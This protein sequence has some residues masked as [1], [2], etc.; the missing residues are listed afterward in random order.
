MDSYIYSMKKLLIG[1]LL[2]VLIQANAQQKFENE[3]RFTNDND[4]YTSLVNDR[5]YTNGIFLTYRYISKKSS[6]TLKKIYSWEI[7]QKMYTPYKSTELHL[8]EHDRPFAAYLYGAFGVLNTFPNGHILKSQLQ[9][10]VVGPS[11]LG[12]EMQTFVHNLYGFK[13]PEGWKYQIQNTLGLNIDLEYTIPI[14]MSEFKKVDLNFVNNLKAGT[15]FN[16]LSTGLLG[17]IGF[18]PLV[19]A[20]NSVAFDTH[21]NAKNSDVSKSIESFFYYKGQVRIV[22]YDTT[23]QGSI[24]NDNSLFTNSSKPFQFFAELGFQAT[25]KKT[26]WKYAFHWHT[27]KA[28][29]LKYRNNNYGTISLAFLID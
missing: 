25:G 23:L 15:V 2:F 26:V 22:A 3:V 4:L 28:E 20:N 17:R 6:K 27:S 29:N 5:Y 24:F 7:A 16:E 14:G 18:K 13:K 1:F 11:A 8:K 19:E 12:E 9:L 10:G 21:L